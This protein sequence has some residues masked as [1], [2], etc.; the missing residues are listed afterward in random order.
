[1]DRNRWNS[2]TLA[3]KDERHRLLTKC[4]PQGFETRRPASSSRTDVVATEAVLCTGWIYRW[5]EERDRRFWQRGGPPTPCGWSDGGRT[6]KLCPR[7]T[8]ACPVSRESRRGS[9][10]VASR[11]GPSPWAGAASPRTDPSERHYGTGLLPRMR[12]SNRSEGHGC[13][14][15]VGGSYR[16]ISSRIR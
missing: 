5:C 15:R 8:S 1:M 6:I 13:R 16:L 11:E 4:R 12:A 2:R 14:T 7:S 10:E 9:A 3:T